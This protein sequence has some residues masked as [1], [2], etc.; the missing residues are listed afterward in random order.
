MASRSGIEAGRA[1]VRMFLMDEQMKA[2]LAK[3]QGQLR[4]TA[5]IVGNI[6]AQMTAVGIGWS[7]PF[8]AA[9]ATFIPFSDAMKTVGAVSQ[10]TEAE[11]AMLTTTAKH[12]GA[13]TSFTA[14][15]VAQ[16]MTEL[17][18]AGFKPQQVN[19]MTA[20]VMNLARA[21]GTEAAMASGI[22]AAT[23]RQF[24]LEATD[25]A[26]V[27]DVLTHAANATFNSVESLGEALK[28]AGPVAKSLGMS[29]EDTVAILGTLGNMGIQGSE[30]G[31]AL[32]RLSVLSAAEAGKM[33]EVFGVA[34]LD[35]AGNA[36]PLVDV[37]GDVAM[38]LNGL[39]SGERVGKM[40]EAFGLLGITAA[41][42][43]A[44]TTA[45]TIKLSKELENLDGTAAKTA[46]AMDS[47]LGGSFR[48]FMS[49]VEGVAIALAEAIEGPLAAWMEWGSQMAGELL[50]LIKHNHTLV[51][52]LAY[53]GTIVLTA[54]GALLGFA[55]A[56]KLVAFG[57][58][59]W[60]AATKA[61]T[62]AQTMLLALSGPKG[63]GVLLIG[64]GI[65]AAAAYKV[66]TAYEAESKTLEAAIAKNDEAAKALGDVQTQL[67]E[68]GKIPPAK[69][70]ADNQAAKIDEAD[71][72]MRKLIVSLA[73]LR[74][75]TAEVLAQQS[76]GDALT[77]IGLLGGDAAQIAAERLRKH[78]ED[79]I[80]P[81]EQLK[82]KLLEVDAAVMA[83]GSD[84]PEGLS[85]T[86][87][88][89]ILEQSTGALS[90]IRE[91]R[92][93]IALL[94]GNATESGQDIAK[95]AEQGVP[96]EILNQYR[97]L[98]EERDR[99]QEQQKQEEEAKQ[100]AESEMDSL[101]QRAEAVRNETRTPQEKLDV[102]LKQLQELKATLDPN[103]GTPLL[104]EQTYQRAL[105]K[106]H[107]EQLELAGRDAQRLRSPK[108]Q[109]DQDVRSVEGSKL[110]VDL[111]N[112]RNDNDAKTLQAMLIANR[113]RSTLI[114]LTERQGTLRKA[115]TR[116]S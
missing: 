79:A 99:L 61:A 70:I 23:L 44:E 67:K 110:L 41:S 24:G 92:D 19:E 96:P 53:I 89:D 104:D 10:S 62:V 74:G 111:L 73:G 84:V 49:A 6:G 16:M 90:S 76:A 39:A 9:V 54:G 87:K 43:M 56:A 38:S 108:V 40:N 72:S 71:E 58:M 98:R 48:I 106:L 81:A 59:A 95:L 93:E 42:V 21:S 57:I 26:H 29:L 46:A 86:L 51:Q 11:L 113:Q 100:K 36:R 15:Q 33:Q 47:G 105:R 52:G 55:A 1:F 88:L 13:T 107:E 69:L 97:Q 115:S 32:R 65:A 82:R 27:A 4:A 63:W 103:T 112:G 17:G 109:S 14:T 25:A 7:L 28:Y 91:L 101:R 45:D 116:N 37:L 114:T 68:G 12:L 75:A 2:G 34:F 85:T 50:I 31:T 83:L 5:A 60:T 30:A 94:S 18:R 66:Q 77:Q 64:A 80:P 20:A 22:M 3:V 35:A 78:V 102:E 8:A